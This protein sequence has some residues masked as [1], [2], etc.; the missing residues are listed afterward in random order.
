MQKVDN[1]E[2]M[3][4]SDKLTAYFLSFVAAILIGFHIF[5]IKYINLNY[6]HPQAIIYIIAFLSFFFWCVSRVLIYYA[7]S[8][9]P[10]TVVHIILNFSVIITTLLAVLIIKTKVQW[11]KFIIGIL[12]VFIGVFSVDRSIL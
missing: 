4:K 5:S 7:S 3:F 9:I 12:F 6:N 1:L 8:D 11:G 10:I 2:K